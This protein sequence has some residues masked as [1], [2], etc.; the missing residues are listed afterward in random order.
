MGVAIVLL[1]DEK[2]EHVAQAEPGALRPPHGEWIPSV[3]GDTARVWAVGDADPPPSSR[4]A[5]LI[6]HADPDRVLYLGDVYP[7]GSREDFTRW[8]KPWGRLIRRMSPT[9]GNHEWAEASEGYEPFWRDITGETPP[10]YYSFRAAGWEIMSVNGEHAEARAVEDWLTERA[11]SGGNCRIAFWHRP[12][13]S[14]GG[15]AGD[16]RA[17]EFWRALQGGARIV[18]NGHD[19]NMQRMRSRNGMV[20]FVSGAGGRERYD[21][22]QGDPRLVFSDDQHYGA[23]RLRLSHEKAKWRFITPRHRVLDSGS[24]RCQA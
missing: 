13:Y 16:P 9:P 18:I 11:S 6:R 8:A 2:V 7:V 17:Q 12:A 19:H 15:H 24:L 23:L 10:T 20:E 3:P 22:A 21:V 4:V 14:A 5:R 1:A